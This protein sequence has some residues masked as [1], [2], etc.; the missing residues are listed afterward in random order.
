M[1]LPLHVDTFPEKQKQWKRD[2]PW[3]MDLSAASSWI[4]AFPDPPC[5][6]AAS[7][8]PS[9]HKC[10]CQARARIF[11]ALAAGGFLP[12]LWQLSWCP[13]EVY[14]AV[15]GWCW[16][17]E[18]CFALLSGLNSLALALQLCSVPC[19]TI[20]M[21]DLSAF[22]GEG[23]NFRHLKLSNKSCFK[24]EYEIQVLSSGVTIYAQPFRTAVW[25]FRRDFSLTLLSDCTSEGGFPYWPYGHQVRFALRMT[26]C[27]QGTVISEAAEH[28]KL[29]VPAA[30]TNSLVLKLLT[31]PS[32]T[33]SPLVAEWGSF[34]EKTQKP[35]THAAW[36]KSLALPFLTPVRVWLR[37]PTHL[38]SLGACQ[39][40]LYL[41]FSLHHILQVAMLI[42]CLFMSK[43]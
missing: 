37:L 19:G 32:T 15:L 33:G 22:S 2:C 7:V 5:P 26:I 28:P 40:F 41:F 13:R 29:W 31:A 10:H 34:G 9:R 18:L 21:K 30:A 35:P 23:V 4:L 27:L 17:P 8:F 39:R 3:Q 16:P 42:G 24:Q 20:A 12:F 36:N 38:L 14:G 6:A 11:P 43:L 1:I 25:Q